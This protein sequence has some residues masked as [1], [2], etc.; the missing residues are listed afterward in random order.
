MIE[1]VSFGFNEETAANNYFQQNDSRP[2][3]EIQEKAL[4]EF[5]N[6]VDVLKREGVNVIVIQDTKEPH[7][8]DS[9]F[10]NNWISF[11]YDA[12]VAVYPMFAPNRRKERRHD[13]LDAIIAEGFEILDI[14]DLS[15][16]EKENKFLEGTGSMILDRVNKKVYAALSERTDTDILSMF[17]KTLRFE[18]IAFHAYQTVNGERL[19]VYHTNV[20]MS[21][22]D[23]FAVV[24]LQSVDN[25]EERQRLANCL[26]DDFKEI[27]EI[28]EEQMHRFAGN[29]LQIETERGDKLIVMSQTAY[30]SLDEKQLVALS[31]YGKIVVIPVPTLEQY[32][33]GSVRC[34]MAEVFLPK[35]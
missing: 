2:S 35:K 24:C 13:V 22:G 28:S 1:P 23:K 31:K 21:V 34:M 14:I 9:I 18:T 7:T 3:S 19:P 15:D 25:I 12:N 26:H 20:M 6:M 16:A 5:R 10:P 4:A 11:H 32:G 27:I 30:N 29:M 33:G 17:A 8:P